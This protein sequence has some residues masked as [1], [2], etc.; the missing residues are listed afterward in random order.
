MDMEHTLEAGEKNSETVTLKLV[1][2]VKSCA[3]SV[4][5][6][7]GV[8]TVPASRRMPAA[9]ATES[10]SGEPACFATRA[11][12]FLA[13]PPIE[14]AEVEAVVEVSAT[15]E[16]EQAVAEGS[17][18]AQ[19]AIQ[20]AQQ[21]QVEVVNATALV[22]AAAAPAGDVAWKKC[23]WTPEE[24]QQLRDLMA[25]CGDGEK[26]RWSAIGEKMSGR[27]GKQCRERWHNHLSPD[28]CKD[29]WTEAEDAQLIEEVGKKG[30]RWAE[31]VKWFPGRTDNGIK[32]R[33]N[34]MIRKQERRA[35]KAEKPPDP[36][37]EAKRA[38]TVA[39]AVVAPPQGAGFGAPTS[40]AE[41]GA[42]AASAVADA[43][44]YLQQAGMLPVIP[45]QVA[46]GVPMA[47]GGG[48]VLMPAPGMV[49]GAPQMLPAGAVMPAPAPGVPPAVPP[50]AP[51]PAAVHPTTSA[52]PVATAFEIP[53]APQPVMV[54][55]TATAEGAPWTDPAAAAAAPQALPSATAEVV[56]EQPPPAAP[57]GDVGGSGSAFSAV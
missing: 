42:A 1:R 7:N 47:V 22:E 55:A 23:V 18:A 37:K 40:V 53:E 44:A 41:A 26:V 56:M 36:R 10:C 43:S 27:S 28:V 12:T 48:G 4:K 9:T 34:S 57:A 15:S 35:R 45:G 49:P 14:M 19:A 3:S 32:N 38:K 51:M 5:S 52:V 16:V 50:A 24:D 2:Q 21:A 54:E 25:A 6:H 20:A 13:H 31:I 46:P 33:Y 11:L 30:T 17:A 39:M 8:L 29:K